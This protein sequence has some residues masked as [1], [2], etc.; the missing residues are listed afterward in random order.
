MGCKKDK[1]KENCTCTYPCKRRGVCCECVQYHRSMGELPGCFFPPDAEK[2]YD[3][4]IGH[5]I[6]IMKK[7]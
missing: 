1:N 5:F 6:S 7:R 2:T 4:S 3:R